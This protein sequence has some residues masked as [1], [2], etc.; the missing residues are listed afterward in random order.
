MH[1]IFFHFWFLPR[2]YRVTPNNT[3]G[4]FFCLLLR[5]VGSWKKNGFDC[6]LLHFFPQQKNAMK[7]LKWE[8]QRR[9]TVTRSPF[10]SPFL[11]NQGENVVF[12]NG[13]T[14]SFA[15]QNSQIIRAVAE[16]VEFLKK[17][18]LYTCLILGL[19]KYYIVFEPGSVLPHLLLQEGERKI[20]T[21][22]ARERERESERKWERDEA[23]CNHE[24]PTLT[25]PLKCRPWP[26]NTT[27]VGTSV[28][29]FIRR[30][31]CCCCQKHLLFNIECLVI[32]RYLLEVS[33]CFSCIFQQRK[34]VQIFTEM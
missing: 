28:T 15:S 10:N 8:K 11:F 26:V 32:N 18:N 20:D 3:F 17:V 27:F 30:E 23:Q 29:L 5:F 16:S 1:N 7:S 22:R 12:L 31:V 21:E 34:Y 6:G 19:I 33:F 9:K 4:L 13:V 24:L 14:L 2:W 25:C